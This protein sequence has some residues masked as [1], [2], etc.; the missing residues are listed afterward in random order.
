MMI[1]LL[2]HKNLYMTLSLCTHS[3][4]KHINILHVCVDI[5]TQSF[6]SW[7]G[8]LVS[9]A[10]MYGILRPLMASA[11]PKQIQNPF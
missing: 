7:F 2:R 3:G 6:W 8:Y 9:N 5:I 10:P 11:D 1:L 4:Q